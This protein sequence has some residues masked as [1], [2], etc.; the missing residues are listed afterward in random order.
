MKKYAARA[1][2]HN[3]DRILWEVW[4]PIGVNQMSEARDE[5][6]RYVNDVFEL[7]VN[8]ASDNAIAQHLLEIAIKR[9]ELTRATINQMRP[10]VVVLRAIDMPS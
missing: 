10:T 4:D 5:Y 6:S 7:L 8:G 2:K 1:V 3:I 9:M